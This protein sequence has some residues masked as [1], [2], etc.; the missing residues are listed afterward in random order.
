MRIERGFGEYFK[1]SLYDARIL[2]WAYKWQFNIILW[3]HFFLQWR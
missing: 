3:L 1:Y 2:N